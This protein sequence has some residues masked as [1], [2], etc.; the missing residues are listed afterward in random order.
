M[1][2]RRNLL[3]RD[4]QGVT[5]VTSCCQTGV[6]DCAPQE[7]VLTPGDDLSDGR[8]L[9]RA[10]AKSF[11]C[12][13]TAIVSAELRCSP[14]CGPSRETR[15]G[16][17]RVQKS[18]A[19]HRRLIRHRKPPTSIDRG[20]LTN[21]CDGITTFTRMRPAG[22]CISAGHEV[23]Q[24]HRGS[25]GVGRPAAGSRTVNLAPPSAAC[26]ASALPPSSAA[27]RPTMASPSPVPTGRIPR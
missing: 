8:S 26:P 5:V 19:R 9:Q 27:S 6:T 1:I 18:A 22:G 4:R 10:L 24:R 16:R 15:H 17:P 21:K 11:V 25:G 14:G 12:L 13:V 3:Q 2:N 7:D 23:S 20:I